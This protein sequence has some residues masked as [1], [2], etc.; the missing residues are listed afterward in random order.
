MAKKERIVR[1][2]N[3]ELRAMQERGES[4]SD[5]AAAGAMTA[6]EI[7]AAIASDADEA[8]MELDWS[9][10]TVELPQPK[11]VRNMRVDQDILEGLQGAG[12]G[13]S[14]EDQRRAAILCG[15]D[16]RAAV[17]CLAYNR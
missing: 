7:E 4:K 11:A 15:P 10:T 3:E 14:D 13:L 2:T 9:Q 12:Q 6:G 5:W 8:G 17:K 16:V 1:H